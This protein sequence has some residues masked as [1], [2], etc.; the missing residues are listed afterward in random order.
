M[1][2]V[3]N[4]LKHYH[5]FL[6][7]WWPGESKLEISISAILVQNTN[8]K[9]VEKTISKL[10]KYKLLPQSKSEN[11]LD[12]A[13]KILALSDL[14]ISNI[15]KSV[16]FY[17][18]KSI[19]I[20]N[21]LKFLIRNGGFEK[22]KKLKID[23]LR[24]KLLN[25]KGIGKETADAIILYAFE[26]PSF[27]IDKYTI[28]ILNRHSIKRENYEEYKKFV[29]SLIPYNV[30]VYKELHAFF[31]EISKEFCKLK[32]ADCFKCPLKGWFEH[33]SSE[34]AEPSSDNVKSFNTM[35][36]RTTS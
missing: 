18:Q 19:Y 16:G 29:E 3:L 4:V 32:S 8:W 1:D 12:Y 28:R 10:R 5:K 11:E 22:L 20:K 17:R 33:S 13:Q 31:I 9:N 24:K 34:P 21:F 6:K 15:I 26:K 2:Y 30:G 36:R 14:E 7:D 23:D 35:F 25:I 27:I